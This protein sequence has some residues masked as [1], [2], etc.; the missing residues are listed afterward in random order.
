VETAKLPEIADSIA[1]VLKSTV[2]ESEWHRQDAL[3]QLDQR[4]RTVVSKLDRGYD[5]YVSSKISEEFWERKSQEW[6]A[7]LLSG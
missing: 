6:E 2:V 1:T 3:R 5:D 4:R 7:E